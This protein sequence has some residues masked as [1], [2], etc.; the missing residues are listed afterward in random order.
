MQ[1][2]SAPSVGSLPRATYLLL[3][4]YADNSVEVKGRTRLEKLAFLVQKRVLESLKLSVSE[5]AYN[6]RPF[7]YGPFTEEVFDDVEALQMFGLV[8]IS[9]EGQEFQTYTLT[10]KGRAAVERLIT[11]ERIPPRLLQGVETVKKT[12]GRLPLDDLIRRVYQDY[13]DYTDL[14]VVKDRYFY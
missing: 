5:E 4:L 10:A 12:Y 8:S 14:S 3:L 11:S 1:D 9:G 13:P 2:T 6:F 7:Y